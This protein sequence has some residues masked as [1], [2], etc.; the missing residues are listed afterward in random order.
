[1][2]NEDDTFNALKYGKY[3]VCN[4]CKCN[5]GTEVLSCPYESVMRGN[6]K[7]CNCCSQCITT[8]F[9]FI[10]SEFFRYE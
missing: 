4:E 10:E 3:G 7:Y 5:P 1:M 9:N 8:C 6:T 2:N